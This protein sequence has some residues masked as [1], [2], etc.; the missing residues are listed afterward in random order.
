MASEREGGGGRE[1][2][3]EREREEGRE[4]GREGGEERKAGRSVRKRIATKQDEHRMKTKAVFIS[5]VHAK[6]WVVKGDGEWNGGFTAAGAL[7]GS[8]SNALSHAA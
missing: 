6:G 4:G 7:E 2:G 5:K 1:R 3:R 8:A